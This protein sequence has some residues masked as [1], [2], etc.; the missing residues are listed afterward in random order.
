[1]ANVAFIGL[2]K[3]GR[4]MAHNLLK[5]GHQ[6]TVYN[7]SQGAVDEL[8]GRGARRARSLAEVADG[9]EIVFT[10]VPMPADV[11]AIVAGP[12]GALQSARPGTVFVDHSTIDPA[13]CRRVA[14]ACA[15]KGCQ[16]LDA[17]VS[18]G[19]WGAEAATLSIM[20]GGDA[21]AFERVRPVLAAMGKNIWHVG[22]VGA[23]SVVKLANQLLVGIHAAAAVEASALAAKA[24]V[25]PK[26]MYE[27][28]K[29]STGH[30]F[31]MDRVLPKNV[32]VRNFE[33]GFVVD[34][35]QKDVT[36]ATELGRQSGVRML[37][38]AITQQLLAEAQAEG[39][40]RED[41]SALAKPM[42]R[43]SGVQIVPK[44]T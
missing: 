36:L 41:Y 27:I 25:D 14:E 16:F 34:F 5:A 30:S 2:G 20:V 40:G 31:Q 18:G 32:F 23:G 11:E 39:L 29:V 21:G 44:G 37:L 6:V 17:P 12:G 24:G 3:M 1:M 43:L 22:A 10:C 35:L 13:T 33:P 19:P 4:P 15:A 7:R 28:V 42:E 38:G 8:V 26:L 9:N